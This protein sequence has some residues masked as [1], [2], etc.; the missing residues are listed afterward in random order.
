MKEVGFKITDNKKNDIKETAS[1]VKSEL[2]EHHRDDQK[3]LALR[4]VPQVNFNALAFF[5]N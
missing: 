2:S 1:A 3:V 4:Q 5:G